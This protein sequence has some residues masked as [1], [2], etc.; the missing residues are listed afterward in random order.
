[1]A[2]A[3]GILLIWLTEDLG[4]QT[5]FLEIRDLNW[6]WFGSSSIYK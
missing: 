1:M 4:M 2:E 6:G 5:N 3:G